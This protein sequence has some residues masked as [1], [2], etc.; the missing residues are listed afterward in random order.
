MKGVVGQFIALAFTACFIVMQLHQIHE[1]VHSDKQVFRYEEL[2]TAVIDEDKSLDYFK[3]F[4]SSRLDSSQQKT[5][6]TQHRQYQRNIEQTFKHPFQQFV[7]ECLAEYYKEYCLEY[8]VKL[9]TLYSHL[10]QRELFFELNPVLLSYFKRFPSR[11][12]Y[13]PF[14]L[15]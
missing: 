2:I 14:S 6:L 15:S 7:L 11:D 9:S 10:Q 8:E 3:Q 5:D 13:G 12:A 4:V 1:P